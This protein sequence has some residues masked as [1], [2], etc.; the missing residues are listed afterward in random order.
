MDTEIAEGREM[1]LVK[2]M[3]GTLTKVKAEVFGE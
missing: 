3:R 1:E 2:S